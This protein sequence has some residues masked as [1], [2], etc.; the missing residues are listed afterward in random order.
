MHSDHEEEDARWQSANTEKQN[1]RTRELL[2]QVKAF[3]DRAARFVFIDGLCSADRAELF[4]GISSVDR[5]RYEKHLESTVGAAVAA[6]RHQRLEEARAGR[7]RDLGDALEVLLE[8]ADRLSASHQLW[9]RRI[10]Q[11]ASQFKVYKGFTPK[12]AAVI[13]NIYRQNFSRLASRSVTIR[14]D[15]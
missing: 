6:K 13:W 14:H 4:K 10:D 5:R 9:V 8:R 12:Q 1:S 2:G 11:T 3:P 15:L 7:A